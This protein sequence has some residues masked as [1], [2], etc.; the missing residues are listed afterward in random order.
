M[1]EN[2]LISAPCLWWCTHLFDGHL[3][4]T[5]DGASISEVEGVGMSEQI[6]FAEVH[7]VKDMGCRELPLFESWSLFGF[8]HCYHTE[9]FWFSSQ[10]GS[11]NKH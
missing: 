3:Y 6:I 2:L 8:S 9:Y 7:C 4:L 1:L 11:G 10:N 5:V